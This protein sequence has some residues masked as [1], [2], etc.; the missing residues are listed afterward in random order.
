MGINP[1]I[2]ILLQDA[3]QWIWYS[4]ISFMFLKMQHGCYLNNNRVYGF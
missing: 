4:K 2:E 3:G 1:K